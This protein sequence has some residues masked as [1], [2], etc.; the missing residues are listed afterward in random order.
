M[1]TPGGKL[2]VKTDPAI[3]GIGNFHCGNGPLDMSVSNP[4]FVRDIPDLF[5]T[6]ETSSGGSFW[7]QA[8]VH[9]GA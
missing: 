1:C 9:S 2:D 7:V 6:V 8:R 3:A 5:V 4:A